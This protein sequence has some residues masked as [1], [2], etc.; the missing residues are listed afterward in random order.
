M[1]RRDGAFTTAKAFRELSARQ[2]RPAIVTATAAAAGV[3]RGRTDH[4][5]GHRDGGARRDRGR[6]GVLR[7]AARAGR[8]AHPRPARL[9][10]R[11]GERLGRL[12]AVRVARGRRAQ[13]DRER[14]RRRAARR[15][16]RRAVAATGCPPLAARGV[17]RGASRGEPL[18]DVTP[19][20]VGVAERVKVRPA[21]CASSCRQ[22]IN[23]RRY[24][25]MEGSDKKRQQTKPRER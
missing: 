18:G 25:G 6:V 14:R 3:R 17:A 13:H 22:A 4:R 9:E 24:G 12:A 16:R 11:L 10:R 7:E 5:G 8:V 15:R 21:S 19:R 2:W 20:G 1:R 23:G